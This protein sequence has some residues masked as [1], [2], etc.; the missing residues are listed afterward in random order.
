VWIGSDGNSR[1]R[2]KE[3]QKDRER[4]RKG[5]RACMDSKW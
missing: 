5:G 1:E 3:K 4:K 2:K